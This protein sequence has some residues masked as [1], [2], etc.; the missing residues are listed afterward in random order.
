MRLLGHE[1]LDLRLDVLRN[2]DRTGL[3]HEVRAV[4]VPAGIA[5]PGGVS[6]EL[7]EVGGGVALDA[8]EL[9]E[10]PAVRGRE[11]LRGGE[12]PDLG[13]GVEF[14]PAVFLRGKG[15]DGQFLGPVLGTERLEEGVPLPGQPSLGGHVRRVD[16]LPLEIGGRNGRSVGRHAREVVKGAA[17]GGRRHGETRCRFECCGVLRG[18]AECLDGR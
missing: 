15:Q 3:R 5:R 4:E 13:V 11:V 8:P 14:L 10:D 18:L 17:A 16:D 6:H 1:G 12:G 7:P 2:A 9:H